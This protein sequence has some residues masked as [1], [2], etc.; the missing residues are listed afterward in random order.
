MSK[1][2]IIIY[3]TATIM[4]IDL[5]FLDFSCYN[6]GTLTFTIMKAGSVVYQ[7]MRFLSLGITNADLAKMP[8]GSL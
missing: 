4:Q 3:H 7:I 6:C 8:E 2:V 5:Y 1:G